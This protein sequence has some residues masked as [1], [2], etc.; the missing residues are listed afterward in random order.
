[1]SKHESPCLV[2]VGAGIFGAVIAIL[3]LDP[4][5]GSLRVTMVVRGAVV[6][7]AF[8]LAGLAVLVRPPKVLV[9]WV[10]LAAVNA[11]A[12]AV[13]FGAGYSAEGIAHLSP[14]EA[15]GVLPLIAGVAQVGA[16]VAAGLQKG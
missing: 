13:I 11:A 3:S 12:L 4:T 5:A 2:A 15:L 10:L 7:L 6:L 14:F 1:M 9:G 16:I 8:A